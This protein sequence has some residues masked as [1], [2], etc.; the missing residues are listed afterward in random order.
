MG[1]PGLP[2][3]RTARVAGICNQPQTFYP[4]SDA[5]VLG[6]AVEVSGNAGS[7]TR[8]PHATPCL[9][10]T[11]RSPA[12]RYGGAWVPA[13]RRV[14]GNARSPAYRSPSTRRVSGLRL[15]AWVKP[16]A[17]G[18]RQRALRQRGS[19]ATRGLRRRVGLRRRPGLRQR[20][21]LRNVRSGN[22]R[23][24]GNAGSRRRAFSRQRVVRR[25]AGLKPQHCL[26]PTAGFARGNPH[27]AEIQPCP[28]LRHGLFHWFPRGLPRAVEPHTATSPIGNVHAAADARRPR[29]PCP[30]T[31][32]VNHALPVRSRRSSSHWPTTPP[33]RPRDAVRPRARPLTRPRAPAPVVYAG[34]LHDR[35]AAPSSSAAAIAPRPLGT[36]ASAPACRRPIMYAP[37]HPSPPATD[38]RIAFDC[39]RRRCADAVSDAYRARGVHREP[40]LHRPQSACCTAPSR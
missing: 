16:N 31:Q 17:A 25:R 10:A 23:V 39:A 12:T 13:T 18:L 22:A 1:Y 21:G 2:N 33:D 6:N 27:R 8:R 40:D 24:S 36:W 28:L 30:T 35:S 9:S 20:A 5:Q 32:E 38:V 29:C 26:T 34:P 14:Y 37:H 3:T 15:T 7:P 11:R 4:T 19:P